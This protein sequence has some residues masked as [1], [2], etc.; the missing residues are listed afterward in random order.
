MTHYIYKITPARKGFADSPTYEEKQIMSEHFAYLNR[1]LA[2]GKL[3]L[4]GPCT[5]AAFGIVIFEAESMAEATLIM[6]SDP[7]VAA[8]VMNAELHEFRVSLLRGR[9]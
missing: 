2:E 3:L 6:Q 9:E 7:A 5:D 8:G 1:L 4:A